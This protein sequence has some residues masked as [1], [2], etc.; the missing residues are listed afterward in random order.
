M[1]YFLI[2]LKPLLF[3][4]S[5]LCMNSASSGI[6]LEIHCCTETFP[7]NQLS[8]EW[9][10]NLFSGKGY[11]HRKTFQTSVLR[12]VSTADRLGNPSK[13]FSGEPW[14][15]RW[16]LM[17]QLHCRCLRGGDK[18]T[19]EVSLQI[20]HTPSTYAVNYFIIKI[21]LIFLNLIFILYWGIVDFPCCVS[22]R[23]TAKWFS[24]TYMYIYSGLTYTYCEWVSD[25]RSV[26]SDTLRPRGLSVHGI[27][28]ARKLAWVA[29]PFSRG[30]SQPRDQTQVSHIAGGFFT[31]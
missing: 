21:L 9:D 6:F 12:Q 20:L 7:E 15:P 19:Q 8:W 14:V 24:Y 30:S 4:E 17:G 31:S 29:F 16:Y 22:F 10:G 28:Q 27:L 1:D 11:Y 25:S 23:C 3:T 26:V 18:K 2:S 13:A 5:S